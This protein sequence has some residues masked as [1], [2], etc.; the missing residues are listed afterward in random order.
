M[1]QTIEKARPLMTIKELAE[2]LGV[3]VSTIIRWSDAGEI[4]APMT[5]G[6]SVRWK[7]ATIEAWL[8][9]K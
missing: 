2:L 8:S 7:R 9:E 1:E 4:P 3:S 6:G 5:I